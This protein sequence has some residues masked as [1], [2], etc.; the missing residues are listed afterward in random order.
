LNRPPLALW[1][2]LGL[3]ALS[4]PAWRLVT[5]LR[6]RTGRDDPARVAEKHGRYALSRPAGPLVWFH[7]V[8]VGEAQALVTLL[9]RLTAARPDLQVLLT[10]HTRTSAQVLA[11]RG[12]PPRVIHQFAPADYPGA[13][14]RF[15]DHWRPDAGVVAEADLWPWLLT[16]ARARGMPLLLLN[17]HVTARRYRRRRRIAASNGALLRLFEAI[18]VQ[19]ADSLT[20]YTELGAPAERMAVMGVLKAAAAPLPDRPEARAALAAQIGSRPVWLAASTRDLEEPQLMQAQALA[21]AERPDLLLIIAPRQPQAAD[22]TEAAARARFP[23]EAIARRSRGEAITPATAVYIADTIGEMG[24]WYRLAPVAYT[25]NSLPVP[26]TTLTGKNPFEAAAL[27]VLILHGPH[28]GNFADAY[29]RL[30][31]AGGAVQVD[32]PEA[33]A[34]AVLAAQDPAFRAPYLAG[35]ARVQAENRH[36]LEIALAATLALI[37]RRPVLAAA[38]AAALS[39]GADPV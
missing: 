5:A 25:G 6:A 11:A 2:Y 36:P 1:A 27:G 32:G 21:R 3:A 29:A 39:T 18:L 12:L 34:R 10:T 14:A 16:R 9:D 17:T 30:Q 8:S 24:L 37:D 13:V 23:A 7:A 20:R 22:A 4:G 19:D 33:L 35:A 26:G 15:L 38:T 28:V 31:A